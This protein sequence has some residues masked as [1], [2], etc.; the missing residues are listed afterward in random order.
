MSRV[1]FSKKILAAAVIAALGASASAE[2]LKTAAPQIELAQ[3]DGPLVITPQPD[4]SRDRAAEN[5]R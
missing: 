4:P 2:E 3:G 5:C 1:G